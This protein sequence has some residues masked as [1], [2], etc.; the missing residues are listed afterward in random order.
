MFP[1]LVS[2]FDKATLSNLVKESFGS[3][4]PDIIQKNQVTY[5]YNYLK[6]LDAKSILLESE[7]VDKDFLEDYSNYYVKCF[8]DYGS[9][10]A[11]IH[12]FSCKVSHSSINELFEV[13]NEKKAAELRNEYLGFIVIK[14]LPKTFIGKTCLKRYSAFDTDAE[15]RKLLQREYKVNLFGIE[16]CVNSVAFQEQDRVL[17]ACATTAIWSAMHA[18]HW[19]NV[20]DIP[21]CGEIT[22]AAINHVSGSSNRFPNHGLTNKQILRALDVDGLKHHTIDLSKITEEGFRRSVRYH[23]DSK[24]PLIVGA[25]I[26]EVSDD[27]LIELGGHAVTI[28]G[29]NKSPERRSLYIHDDRIGPFARASFGKISKY[30]NQSKYDIDWC[31]LLQSKDDGSEW[32]SPSQIIIPESLIIPSH[33]KSRIPEHFVRNTCQSVL[34]SYSTYLQEQTQQGF[35]M[36][37]HHDALEYEIKLEEVRDIKNRV[38]SGDAINKKEVLLTSLARFQWCATIR[39]KGTLA[40]E[41]LFDATDIPQGNAV[42]AVLVYN[43]KKYELIVDILRNYCGSGELEND[44]EGENFCGALLGHIKSAEHDHNSYLDSMYGELRA[45][46]YIRKSEVTQYGASNENRKIFYGS[47]GG[48]IESAFLGGDYKNIIWAISHDGALILGKEKEDLGH[49]SITGMK[50]ARIAGELL[51]QSLEDTWYI[52]SKSGRYSKDYDNA[53]ELLKNALIRFG[54]IF[55]QSIGHLRDRPYNPEI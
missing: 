46:L 19:K 23:I 33:K 24:L 50:P 12:F 21:S 52:N 8:N 36:S 6:D 5:I 4:F 16:F 35:D 2:E 18:L 55:P 7:Y 13:G 54:E 45:P 17:S 47:T 28:L 22:D 15:N 11:R 14:P 29:Y 3:T 42:S 49:P 37:D 25:R 48:K 32:V 41:I 1:Y 53:N 34:N 39:V 20:R 38:L 40:V 31:L 27:G 30:D 26:Y 44:F 43:E 9:K 10:C 51:Y